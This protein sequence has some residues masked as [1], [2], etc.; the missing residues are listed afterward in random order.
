MSVDFLFFF[1]FVLFCSSV[2]CCS[3]CLLFCFCNTSGLRVAINCIVQHNIKKNMKYG[4][5]SLNCVAT[6]APLDASV[7][8]S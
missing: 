4:Q 5:R 3:F 1:Y 6:H 2:F 7:A 8:I